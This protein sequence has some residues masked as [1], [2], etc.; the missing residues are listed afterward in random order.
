MVELDHGHLS[1]LE[2][3]DRREVRL[4]DCKPVA[5]H[6]GV[7]FTFNKGGQ[8]P[9]DKPQTSDSQQEQDPNREGQPFEEPREGMDGCRGRPCCKGF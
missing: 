9:I 8:F 7:E 3:Q 5:L 2:R 4:A 1:D 6:V